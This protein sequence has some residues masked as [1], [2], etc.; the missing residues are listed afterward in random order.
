M[1]TARQLDVAHFGIA[2]DGVPSS[3]GDVFPE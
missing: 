2:V 1:H 3:R